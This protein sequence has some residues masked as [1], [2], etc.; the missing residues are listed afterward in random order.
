MADLP[1]GYNLTVY[2]GDT[3]NQMFRL[4]YGAAAYDLTGLPGRGAQPGRGHV[5]HGAVHR[6]LT[7]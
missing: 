5:E 6:H 7:A 2:R 4:K 3:W 1:A